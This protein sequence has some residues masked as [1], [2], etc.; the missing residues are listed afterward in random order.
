MKFNRRTFIKGMAVTSA[1]IPFFGIN[2]AQVFEVTKKKY[3]ISF[4]TKPL[5]DF[6]LVFIAEAL[7]MAGIDGFDLA[8]RPKGRVE[9]ERISNDLPKVIEISKKYHLNTDMMVTSITNPF[10]TNTEHVLKTA[11]GLGIKHYRLGY[12]DYDFKEGIWK[13]LDKIKKN[14]EQLTKMNED[15]GI[16]GGYQ[17]HSGTKVGSPIWD[18]WELIRDLPPDFMSSQFDIRHA[19][20][21]GASSWILALQ[22]LS[23]NIGSLAIKDFTWDVSGRKAKVVSVPLG[24]GIVDFN[25][26]FTTLKELNINV[27][28]T[29][30]IEYPFFSK[31]EENVSLTQKQ[32]IITAKIKKDTDFIRYNLAKFKLI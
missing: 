4:F 8:V 10:G 22:L 17:N 15:I 24:E 13:S 23:K 20:T 21:E 5:D 30:H 7:A 29:L 14:L 27:P 3:P 6:D 1:A 26:F 16:Q 2:A 18:I 19:V 12:Y 31:E 11:A 32:K 9:P 25:L 28:I